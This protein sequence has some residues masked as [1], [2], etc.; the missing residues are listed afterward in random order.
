[1]HLIKFR[2]FAL[3][4]AMA[5]VCSKLYSIDTSPLNGVSDIY[6]K[7]YPGHAVG[8]DLDNDGYLFEEEA[9]LGTDPGDPDSPGEGWFGIRLETD[10]TGPRFV[11]DIDTEQ[12]IEYE[13]LYSL[14]LA[15]DSW[16][17][18]SPPLIARGSGTTVSL[19][20]SQDIDLEMRRFW[21]VIGLGGSPDNDS[22]GL[23][24]WEELIGIKL[25]YGL[26][27]KPNDRDTDNDGVDDGSEITNHTDPTD[28]Y[29]GEQPTIAGSRPNPLV[30]QSLNSFVF[31]NF[32]I[33][34]S[35]GEQLS[36][37]P[38]SI[39]TVGN[40]IS[41]TNRGAGLTNSLSLETDA[42]GAVSFFCLTPSVELS[43]LVVTIEA[44]TAS[45]TQIIQ[46]ESSGI[47]IP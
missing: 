15:I 27:T 5:F 44:G 9:L 17:S 1:M 38:V 7:I 40:S 31:L 39:T 45:I 13:I 19:I 29:N 16:V 47:I 25:L 2:F 24:L 36:D 35:A 41:E 4:V 30:D 32:T 43:I 23:D 14:D 12:A 18:E 42:N 37:A 34:T 3:W 33:T 26:P 20:P 21:S 11:L 8:S 46:T 6:E 22:D 10:T 28:Y